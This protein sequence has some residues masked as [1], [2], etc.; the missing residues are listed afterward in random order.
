MQELNS[1]AVAWA[2]H[3]NNRLITDLL[4]FDWACL[5]LAHASEAQLTALS[6]QGCQLPGHLPPRRRGDNHQYRGPGHLS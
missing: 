5:R 3:I 4:T 1:V 2:S 6:K